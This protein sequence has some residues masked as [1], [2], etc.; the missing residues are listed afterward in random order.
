MNEKSRTENSIRNIFTGLFGQGLQ[1]LLS[2]IN[3]MVFIRCLSADYLGLNGLF[4]NVLS[5]LSLA[6]L[7]I[8][9]AIVYA[10]YKPLAEKD[11][12]KIA[13]Y[14][15]F[16]AR[17]YKTIGIIVAVA[18]IIMLPFLKVIIN[19]P[20]QIHENIYV[21]Y[22]ISLFNTSITYFF[23]YKSSLLIADQKNYVVLLCS[24]CTSFAQT[25]FQIIILL[26]TR[27]YILYLLVQT[28]CGMIYNVWISRVADKSY[29]FL[30]NTKY[31]LT[32]G[33]KGRLV[34]DIRALVI[35]KLSSVLVNNTDNILIT[36]FKGL[37]TTGV[38]SNYTLLVNTLN[39][40]LNQIFN[41]LT[42]SV[43]NLNAVET[44]EKKY[45]MFKVLN[46]A[47]F[48][49]FGWAT[50][51]FVFL[52]SIIVELFFGSQ[53]VLEI[54]IV[55]I[56]AVNFYTVGM[57]NAVW[58]YRGTLGLFRYGRYLLLVTAALNLFLSVVLGQRLGVF[59]ILLATF[60]SRIL[61][62]IWYDPFAVF[63]HGLHLNPII[64][65][66]M[67]IKYIGILLIT[68]CIIF[69]FNQI[70]KGTILLVI[71]CITIPHAVFY[72]ALRKTEECVYLKSM[73]L[74][75]VRRYLQCGAK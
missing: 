36:F 56:M 17:A 37:A 57:Q 6:E 2:F 62:N 65:L 44:K 21:L 39:N 10:L 28:A 66:H 47:N 7:G 55:I 12:K 5:V 53:Y 33:E 50:I 58:T 13:A 1:V 72:I 64:Y 29:P 61:T 69:G 4:T 74:Q 15:N 45:F 9:S 30:G 8:G 60:I 11:E 46:L 63:K 24:Y 51:G 34:R 52:S 18:G 27:N 48:W 49:L 67:Y 20:Y 71:L 68:I 26:L 3:R 59:G 25:I 19:V 32:S 40:L 35:T 23:S 41:G 14:M 16:Y 70:L 75:L 54:D 22:C 31:K 42:A 73:A 38:T 43:G